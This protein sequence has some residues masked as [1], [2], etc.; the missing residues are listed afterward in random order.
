MRLKLF[1]Y[2]ILLVFVLTAFGKAAANITAENVSVSAGNVSTVTQTWIIAVVA[3][4]IISLLM[5]FVLWPYLINLKESHKHLTEVQKDIGKFID[6]YADKIDEDKLVQ[7]IQEDFRAKP[8]GAPGVTRGLMALAITLVVGISLF[9]MFAYPPEEPANGSIKE[10]LLTLTG[11]LTAIVGFYFGGKASE[12]KPTE[13]KP[14]GST[15][16]VAKTEAEEAKLKK[17][18][19][20]EDF[21]YDNLNYKKDTTVDLANIPDDKLKELVETKKIA[22]YVGEEKDVPKEIEGKPGWY[23]IKV[24]FRYNDDHYFAGNNMNLTDV[25]ADILAGWIAH[26]W[27]EPYKGP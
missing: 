11:A 25:P 24:G 13:P 26:K 27:I 15:P 18:K 5:I 2:A 10:V 8:M 23:T 22:P 20:I 12:P 1:V 17:Y 14:T 21:D 4:I 19:V 7:I 9:F 6:K 3:V 16:P